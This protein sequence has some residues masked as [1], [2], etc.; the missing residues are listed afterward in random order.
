[1]QVDKIKMGTVVDHIKAGKARRVMGLL[2]IGEKYPH[3]VAIVLNVPSKRMGTKDIV[4]IEGK[5]VSEEVANMIALVSP[6]ATVN[7]VKDSKVEKKYEA[8]L[9]KEVKN[10]GKCPN[11]NCITVESGQKHFSMDREKYRCHFCER[12]F[13]AEELV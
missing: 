10:Y 13:L 5:I 7:I 6:G 2:D 9:P 8:H 1:M 11:P 4:K 3:R 12:L